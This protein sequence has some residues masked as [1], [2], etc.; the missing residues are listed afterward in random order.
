MNFLNRLKTLVLVAA[1]CIMPALGADTFKI[2]TSH[3]SI[4]F[5][6][7]HFGAA[8]NYGRFND[9]EGTVVFDE[10]NLAATKVDVKIVAKSID[11]NNERRDKHLRSPDFF[12][13]AQF[14]D[15]TFKSSKVEVD[16]ETMKIHGELAMLGKKQNVVVTLAKSGEGTGMDGGKL[17]GF[18]GEASFK[19]SDFGMNYGVGNG[20]LSD[21]VK[22]VISIETKKV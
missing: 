16:G 7:K 20:A 19:R 5:A 14:P 11:T 3:S 1:L 6:A 21:E 17:V 10:A 8:W 22:I 13:A 2:D 9:F 4:M 12:N 15:I 18:H